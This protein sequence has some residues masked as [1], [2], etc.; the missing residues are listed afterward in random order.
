METALDACE[1]PCNDE[2]CKDDAVHA[3]DQAV[4]FHTGSLQEEGILLYAFADVMCRAFHSCG[5]DGSMRVGTSYANNMAIEH[6]KQGQSYILQKQCSKA[7]E[8][9]EEIVK[10]MTIPLIQATLFTAYAVGGHE[11]A[12]SSG[13]LPT[14][15]AR[16][17][18]FAATVLPIVHD[19][20]ENDANII[21]DILGIDS[22]Q[23]LD[24]EV[25]YV[26]LKAAFERNYE[27]MGVTCEGVG[28]IWEDGKYLEHAAPCHQAK[29][30]EAAAYMYGHF[31]AMVLLPLAIFGSL[32]LFRISKKRSRR[33]SQ[34]EAK[35]T[36][37]DTLDEAGL[38]DPSLEDVKLEEDVEQNDVPQLP[39]IT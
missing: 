30:D 14:K 23:D 2:R 6:F 17:A 11:S 4:A 33:L 16:A 15:K 26:A 34:A 12:L 9:K 31:L 5:S 7:R 13:D 8:S 24:K 3:W 35:Q 18:G 10:A 25:N 1:V 21:Y 22:N 36:A 32:V 20:N 39:P 27:C 37:S 38:E 28:G 29:V 19:C